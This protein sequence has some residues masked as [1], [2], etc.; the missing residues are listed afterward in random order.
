MKYFM[1]NNSSGSTYVDELTKEG[2]LQAIEE[3]TKGYKTEC[4]PKFM[5]SFDTEDT[6]H[7]GEND[8]LII[9]GEIVTPKPVEKVLEYEID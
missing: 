6:N 9:K 2:L 1:I 3:M 7:W 4:L 8:Y 5:S